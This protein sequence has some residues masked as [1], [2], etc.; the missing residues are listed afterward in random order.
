MN[1]A[2]SVSL[3]IPTLS[4]LNDLEITLEAVQ[5]GTVLPD[6]IVIVDASP[7]DR[8]ER[9]IGELALRT[10]AVEFVYIRAE[11]P[12]VPGQRNAGLTRAQGDFILF[13]DNDVTVASNFI[14]ELL[15]AFDNPK[16]GAACGLISNQFLPGG[17]T[18]FLQW[19]FRQTRYA[20]RSYYQRS[21]FPTFLYR[22]RKP[23]VVGALTGGLTMF[24]SEAIG[25]FRFDERILFI[26]DD[27]YSLDLRA[28]GWELMQWS[29]ARAEHREA[30]EGR[31]FA[32]RVRSNVVGRRLLHKRYFP[33]NILNVSSYYYGVLGGAAVAALRLKPRLMLGNVLGLWDVL[34]TG[35]VA[36]KPSREAISPQNP[37]DGG[38]G[39]T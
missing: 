4:R 13:V 33:Q 28:R 34:R 7:D 11:R 36:S 5:A 2:R 22:P 24:R 8:T 26:D 12:G 27:S 39:K 25:D 23:S 30:G 35:R 20:G 37:N 10:R 38:S 29:A 9:F 16:V 18:R 32:G 19:L 1:G 15:K 6:E 17:Y 21:G 31:S 14:E 3:I